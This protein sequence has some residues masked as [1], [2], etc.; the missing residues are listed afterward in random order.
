MKRERP[1]HGGRARDV[2]DRLV[3]FGGTGD[4][5]ARYLLPALAALWARGHLSERFELNRLLA[6]LVDERH[7]FRVDHFLAMTTVQ[8]LLGIRLANRVLEPIARD[9]AVQA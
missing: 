1:A 3:I 8:N 7:V 4:L 2:I 9:V 5:T 6:D